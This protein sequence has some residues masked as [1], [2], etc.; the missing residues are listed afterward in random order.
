MDN[1]LL[2][3]A[4]EMLYNEELLFFTKLDKVKIESISYISL[5]EISAPKAV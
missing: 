5:T 2:Y 1:S 3:R 4:L